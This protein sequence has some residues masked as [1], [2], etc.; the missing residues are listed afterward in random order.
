MQIRLVGG[1]H[2]IFFAARHDLINT[3]TGKYMR[4]VVAQI[5]NEHEPQPEFQPQ[6]SAWGCT[7]TGIADTDLSQRMAN[8]VGAVMQ[9]V[10][11]D[12]YNLSSLEATTISANYTTSLA[13]LDRGSELLGVLVPTEEF[14]V[15]MAMAAPVMR[16]G[17]VMARLM[18]DA[19]IVLALM[20]VDEEQKMFRLCT[21]VHELSHIHDLANKDAA[22]PGTFLKPYP[23]AV[24]EAEMFN[25]SSLAWDE[26][27]A[28]KMSSYLQP[29][30]L[31]AFDEVLDG[32]LN[33]LL[34]R[35]TEARR[36]FFTH[37]D[38]G[39][40]K[41]E[42]F[43]AMQ[44]LLKFSAYVLGSLDGLG[45]GDEYGPKSRERL[46]ASRFAP[47]FDTLRTALRE[48]AST[49]PDWESLQ[50]YAP[51]RAV[52]QKALEVEGFFLSVAPNEQL[53]MRIMEPD[54]FTPEQ[55]IAARFGLRVPERHRVPMSHA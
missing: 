17:K 28:T 18:L 49:Y 23:G 53:W 45:R 8:S 13:E 19:G 39:R 12:G 51:L 46:L 6:E 24:L 31:E 40:T 52:A 3:I 48:M 10:L 4:R 36:S 20:S 35:L 5:M 50:A 47:V 55:R 9:A 42:M 14:G 26:F 34:A 30:S 54:D 43:G 1:K 22:L 37:R 41:R 15:G 38:F 11:A 32:A 27:L 2:A 16:D 29:T 33:E 25:L 44:V 7:V 21:V